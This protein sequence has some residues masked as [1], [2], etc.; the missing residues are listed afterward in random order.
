MA[1]INHFDVNADVVGDTDTVD[2]ILAR[3]AVFAVVVVFPVFH[4][5]AEHLVTLLLEQPRGNGGID[6]AGETNNDFHGGG[7]GRR[8]AEDDALLRRA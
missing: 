3:R 6:A 4:E 2:Q 5:D 7:R 1:K 8:C